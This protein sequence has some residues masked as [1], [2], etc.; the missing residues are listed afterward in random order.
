MS[1]VTKNNEYQQRFAAL[2]QRFIETLPCK[3]AMMLEQLQK[4]A[5]GDHAAFT[6]LVAISHQLSGSCGTFRL[7]ELGQRAREVEQLALN[8][9]RENT[10]DATLF[11]EL[12]QAVA[13]FAQQMQHPIITGGAESKSSVITG[14]DHQQIWLLL[15]NNSLTNELSTQLSAF[16]YPLQVFASYQECL[17][18]L[19]RQ[20]PALLYCSAN[21][22]HGCSQLFEQHQLLI[23]LKEKQIPWMLF[24]DYDEF[25]LRVQAARHHAQAF[26]V[27]PLDVP[28]MLGRISDVLEQYAD[29]S[30]RVCVMD[31]DTLLAEHIALTLQAAGI[32]CLVLTNPA[33]MIADILQYQPE[34]V[35][36]DLHMPTYSGPELAGVIRQY[37]AFK[38]LPIVYLSAEQDKAQQLKAMAYGADDFLTKPISDRQL[39]KAVQVRLQRSRELKNLI[40]KDSLTGLMKHSAIKEAAVLEFQRARRSGKPFCLVMVDIDHFKSVNDRFGHAMGDLVITTLATLLQ[41]RIRRTDKAG[42]YGGE[43]F[44]LVLPDCQRQDAVQLMQTILD[45][46]CSI[47]FHSNAQ[48]FSSSFSAGIACGSEG[49]DHAE[50]MLAK[51]DEKLYQAKSLGRNRVLA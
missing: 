16:D 38:S 24:S 40:V 19:A 9:Q 28:A 17:E 29:C 1:S 33:T 7:T 3:T 50:T 46:F 4:L 20:T 37:D 23:A 26:Y 27:S 43:E 22:D 42:R 5:A 35:L 44:L 2:Q 8:L 45:G 25:S 10:L 32:D 13:S 49:F 6:E 51:A 11:F 12:E 48:D 30:G 14:Q 31:D 18:S 36:L 39:V 21:L 15:D 34:L 41:K 47:I